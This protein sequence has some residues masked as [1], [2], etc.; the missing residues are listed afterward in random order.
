MLDAGRVVQAGSLEELTARPRTSY[1]ADLMGVNLLTGRSAGEGVT[2]LDAGGRIV[3][4]DWTGI[5]RG[6]DVLVVIRPSAVVLHPHEPE[7]SARNHW[8]TTV[9]S[10]DQEPG[11]MR[12][13]LRG[14][15]PIVAEV[16]AAAVSDLGLEPGRAIWAA[17]KAT[18]VTLSRR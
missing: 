12:V 6:E 15:P 3:A 2:D 9:T 17:M 16:T 18:E 8:L 7:G 1:V 4:A 13:C 10:V 11:R 14:A 5:E